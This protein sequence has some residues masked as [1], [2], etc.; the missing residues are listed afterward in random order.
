MGING[1]PDLLLNGLNED[2][3][4]RII[5]LMARRLKHVRTALYKVALARQIFFGA[6]DPHGD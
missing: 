5:D 1:E 2:K 6:R 3:N 4:S